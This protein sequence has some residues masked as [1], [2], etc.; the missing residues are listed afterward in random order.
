MKK[1]EIETFKLFIIAAIIVSLFAI[2]L[3]GMAIHYG[4]EYNRECNNHIWNAAESTTPELAASELSKAISYMEAHNMKSGTS[5][6]AA[7][8]DNVGWYY[9]ALVEAR[10]NLE[11]F[12]ETSTDETYYLELSKATEKLEKLADSTPFCISLYRHGIV[13]EYLLFLF[14]AAVLW[15]IALLMGE[16]YHPSTVEI[17]VPSFKKANPVAVETKL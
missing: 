7:D 1:I 15:I 16:E 6:F 8:E 4:V 12:H 3:T 13:S 2:P 9:Q 14:I 11:S 5:S 17:Y 10:N